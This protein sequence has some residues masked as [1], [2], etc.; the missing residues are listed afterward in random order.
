MSKVRSGFAFAMAT[1]L[2]F[3]GLGAGS[4]PMVSAASEGIPTVKNSQLTMDS[5]AQFL[6]CLSMDKPYYRAGETIYVKGVLLRAKDHTPPGTALNANVQIR[7]KGPKGDFV[8]QG[9]TRLQSNIWSSSWTVPGELPG[10][11]YNFVIT[12]PGTFL[13]SAER[14]FEVKNYRAP[15]LNSQIK[16]QRDG[17]GPGE[18]VT[19]TLEVKR[20]EGGIPAGAPVTVRPN[21]DGTELAEHTVNLDNSGHCTVSFTLPKEIEHGE[22]TLALTISDGG[23]VETAAKSIPILL[24]TVDLQIY[25]EGGQLVGGLKNRVYIQALQS[26]GKPADIEASLLESTAVDKPTEAAAKKIGTLRTEHEG[27]G[28]FEF[29]PSSNKSYAIKIEK[30]LGVKR[31][32]SLPKVERTGAVLRAMKDTYKGSEPIT[33]G[34]ASTENVVRL[35]L[36]KKENELISTDVTMEKSQSQNG[37]ALQTVILPIGKTTDGVLTVTAWS[38]DDKPLAERLVFREPSRNVEFK[39]TADKSFYAPGEKAKLTIKATDEK[40]TPVEAIVGLN[41]SDESVF[42]MVD[43]REQAPALP[44]MFLLEPEVQDLADANV[45]LDKSNSKAPL[46]TDLLLGTQGWRRFATVDLDKFASQ[47]GDK[48]I[49]ALA[50]KA[51]SSLSSNSGG[52]IVAGR[53]GEQG[54]F[55]LLYGAPLSFS[56]LVLPKEIGRVEGPRDMNMFCVEPT[57]IDERHYSAGRSER[58][59]KTSPTLPEGAPIPDNDGDMPLP[60]QVERYTFFG[61]SQRQSNVPYTQ[62][63]YIREYAHVAREK[64]DPTERTDFTETLYWNPSILTDAKTGE[65]K[66]EFALND[67]IT[68]FRVAVDG[69]TQKG[70]LGAGHGEISSLR[71]FYAEAKLPLEVTSGDLPQIPINLVNTTKSPIKTI[72]LMPTLQEGLKTKSK[73]TNLTAVAA[74][75]R[76]RTIMPLEITA[77][78]GVKNVTIDLAGGTFQDKVVRSIKV[79]PNG[80]PMERGFGGTLE[81][82]KP[83]TFKIKIDKD[84]VL[85][86]VKTTT[87][88]NP[89]PLGN[90]TSALERLILDPSGCFE[91]TSSTSYPLTM[92]QQYFQTHRDVD[93]KLVN[94]SR[95][96]LNDGYKKLTSFWCPDKGYEWYGENPGHEALTAFGI[97]HFN[98]MSKVMPVDRTMI[99]TTRTWLMN[100]KDGKGGFSRKRRALHCWIEDKDCSNAYIVWALLETGQSPTTLKAELDSLKEAADKS[101]NSYVLAL[102]A[103]AFDI[104]G[105]HELSKKLMQRLAK[106]QAK[107]GSVESVTSTIV[108]SGGEALQIEGAALATLAWLRD[109]EFATNAASGIKYLGEAC[110]AGR[111][112]STQ[113]TVLALRAILANDKLNAKDIVPGKVRIFCDGKPI[114]DWVS[115]NKSTKEALKLPNLG[116]V[117]TPGEHEI[118]IRMEQG[119]KIPYSVGIN[120]SRATPDSAKECKLNLSVK[121]AQP[122]LAEG[123]STEVTTTVTNLT[124]EAIPNPVAIVGLPGGVEPRID[125]LKELVKKHTIDAYEI[126]GREVVLYWRALDKNETRRVPLSVVAAIPGT[127]AGP[128]SRAYLYYT[129]E[130]KK[131]VDGLKVEIA[132]K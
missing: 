119:M 116:E 127:Y 59:Q 6:T 1:W 28:R 78:D 35:T 3:L 49:H 121:M 73:T 11:E 84:T 54:R 102:A 17:Y 20:A 124:K 125:Q 81:P 48:A 67:S 113:S 32:Y 131:W 19:A 83:A 14:K 9:Y 85:S 95:E 68:S 92:A 23:V 22:G 21:V 36:S 31:L 111:Y 109:P 44:A 29:T 64:K 42:Q 104:A 91:Q 30:P 8:A 45:Y 34:L 70:A 71:P 51:Q 112:G 61:G 47:Y 66:I 24:K 129:D 105:D 97:M 63:A 39:V 26:N 96:K 13:A 120:Y 110:K 15:R 99:E 60:G 122:K 86:S 7:I 90:L 103:N 82:G 41:V 93:Q 87:S 16:F 100:Q 76:L 126:R 79:K 118:Q 25:P 53:I 55:D 46:A 33:I 10:G 75:G 4:L 27:R 115:F 94:T 38:I 132:A 117:L 50:V 56:K 57:V 114:G 74:N 69:F 108:G 130:H 123:Q 98:D 2:I 37:G 101:K 107:D 62:F 88:V 43:K 128:A 12:Y 106:L 77:V 58:H 72:T 52:R 18:L 89:A 65:A 80:F 40:G 5:S